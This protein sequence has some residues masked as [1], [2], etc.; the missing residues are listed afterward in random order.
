MVELDQQLELD[1]STLK[2]G[3]EPF[4]LLYDDYKWTWIGFRRAV[5]EQLYLFQHPID[6]EK[7]SKSLLKEWRRSKGWIQEEM[8]QSSAASVMTHSEYDP[9]DVDQSVVDNPMDP[10]ET[11]DKQET[12]KEQDMVVD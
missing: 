11:S 1:G 2:D 9:A 5:S 8:D 3:Y 6:P 7:P 10:S 4:E 12:N